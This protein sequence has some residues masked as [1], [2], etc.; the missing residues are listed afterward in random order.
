MSTMHLFYPVFVQVL[1]VFCVLMVLGRAR[2]EALRESRISPETRDVALGTFKWSDAAKRA[3]NNFSNQFE[4]P[5]LF[6]AAVAMALLLKQVDAVT[7]TLAWAFVVSRL[8][9][10]IIHI[11]PNVVRWRFAVYALGALCLLALWCV[12]AWRVAGG[13]VA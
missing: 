7:V 8:V 13:A 2:V 1:L 4:L 10:A 6:Y 12:L 3:S 9:H 11:G 5:V